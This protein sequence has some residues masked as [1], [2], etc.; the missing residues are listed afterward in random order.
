MIISREGLSSDRLTS[1][2]NL[3]PKLY[4]SLIDIP[5]SFSIYGNEFYDSFPRMSLDEIHEEIFLP[6]LIVVHTTLLAG[7]NVCLFYPV[8]VSLHVDPY[9]LFSTGYVSLFV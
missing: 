4:V 8:D 9:Y 6:Y 5:T 7:K 1:R 3:T 2:N